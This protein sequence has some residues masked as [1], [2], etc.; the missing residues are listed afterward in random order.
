M[1]SAINAFPYFHEYYFH[2]RD[3]SFG[4]CSYN[5]TLFD[6]LHGVN[7]VSLTW[8]LSAWKYET[9]SKAYHFCRLWDHSSIFIMCPF[10]LYCRISDSV[11]HILQILLS[12]DKK[13]SIWLK[14]VLNTKQDVYFWSSLALTFRYLPY[15]ST[16]K[17]TE[18]IITKFLLCLTWHL[19]LIKERGVYLYH[20][21]N[22]GNWIIWIVIIFQSNYLLN[23]RYWISDP[24]VALFLLH[25]D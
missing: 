17:F 25:I 22:I 14:P 15:Q 4:T 7:K 19:N 23:Q 2:F 12:I 21:C 16:A 20:V 8:N 6:V 18:S 24:T 5:L 9:M 1:P 10:G 11:I 13:C 3:A